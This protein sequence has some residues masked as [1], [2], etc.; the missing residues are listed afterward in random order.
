M[1]IEVRGTATPEEIAAVLAV[2]A[3]LE[4][5]QRV[6]PYRT[7]RATRVAAL[8]EAPDGGHDRR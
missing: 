2:V 8:L 3:R 1:T 5:P 4:R 6:E 7:W